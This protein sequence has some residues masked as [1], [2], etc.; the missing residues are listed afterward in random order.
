ML[1]CLP[2]RQVQGLLVTPVLFLAGGTI[3]GIYTLGVILIGQDFRGQ[4]LALVSTGFAM[5]YSA[6]SVVGSTPVGLAT[7]LFG[8]NALPFS[9]SIGFVALA[10][11][12]FMRRSPAAERDAAA[13]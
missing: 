13:A 11:F 5:A 9:I 6:G 4:R 10:V 7:D 8:P 1:A 3:S 12:L 2:A